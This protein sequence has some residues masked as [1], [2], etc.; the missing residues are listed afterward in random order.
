MNDKRIKH[1]I[2]LSPLAVILI[3]ILVGVWALT[4][5]TKGLLDVALL[6]VG[7]KLFKIGEAHY[8]RGK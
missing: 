3:I 4:Y 2:H 5:G 8:D 1:E 7:Y 6:Y